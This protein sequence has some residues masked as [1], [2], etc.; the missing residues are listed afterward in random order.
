MTGLKNYLSNLILIEKNLR[1]SLWKNILFALMT[2]YAV[3][4]ICY[5]SAYLIGLGGGYIDHL[6]DL[7]SSYSPS[8]FLL[9]AL[10]MPIIEEL[11]FRLLLSRKK[12][13]VTISFSL[14]YMFFFN[15]VVFL[16]FM[17]E[18]DNPYL[19]FFTVGIF[20][21][22]KAYVLMKVPF[23]LGRSFSQRITEA[24]N[25][26]FKITYFF[27]AILFS[28]THLLFQ[29]IL[30]SVSFLTIIPLFFSYFVYG[31]VLNSLR[32]KYGILSAILFHVFL[33]SL[34]Y[35]KFLF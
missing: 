4:L 24:V 5:A 21:F 20:V 33:N 3:N 22:A 8:T 7:S 19:L 2:I 35:L 18:I 9:T 34:V 30:M 16:L 10:L 12:N 15:I 29:H 14:M 23:R 28:L 31:L 1:T 11:T 25:H 13:H 6:N 26:Y 27:T 32:I 17:D